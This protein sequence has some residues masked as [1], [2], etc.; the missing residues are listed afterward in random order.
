MDALIARNADAK[1]KGNN[2]Y[3]E[4]GSE[5][6]IAKQ[7]TPGGTRSF[8]WKIQN[9]GAQ[10]GVYFDGEASSEC[11]RVRYFNES[12]DDIT[13]FVLNDHNDSFIGGYVSD[14]PL[15][16]EIKAK[17]CAAPGSR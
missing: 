17:A 8:A 11:F 7:V 4:T 2:V 14:P 3:T 13:D 9:E 6:K 16:I 12:G 15:R 10:G 5:Q 1:F